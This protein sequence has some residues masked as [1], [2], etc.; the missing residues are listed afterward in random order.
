MVQGREKGVL[1]EGIGWRKSL[2][3]DGLAEPGRAREK[4]DIS[5]AKYL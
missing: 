3:V 5:E 4:Q 1:E 2:A